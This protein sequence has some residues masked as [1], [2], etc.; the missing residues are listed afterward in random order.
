MQRVIQAK[1][2]RGA[3]A[4]SVDDDGCIC[5]GGWEGE[6]VGEQA[7]QG[8]AGAAGVA[9]TGRGAAAEATRLGS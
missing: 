4:R 1:I 9:G 5:G 3:D 8:A 6:K 2:G 7:Q